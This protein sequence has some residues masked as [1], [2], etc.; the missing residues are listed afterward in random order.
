M[1]SGDDGGELSARRRGRP[2]PAGRSPF[3]P[4][5]SYG[6]LSDC[7]TTTLIA[8]SGNVEWLCLPRPDSPSVFGSML[9]RSAGG[10]RIGPTDVTVPAG[11]RYLPGTLVIE[12]TWQLPTG[13]L[14][15]RDALCV[16]PWYHDTHR[17]HSYRRSPTD[18]EAE[19]VLLRT[20][21]CVSGTA[22]VSLTC[23]PVFDYGRRAGHW[24]Y[25]GDGYGDAVLA[26]EGSD[27]ELH[28]TTNMR[29]GFEGRGAHARTQMK[30]GENVFVALA[31]GEQAPPTTWD[32]AYDRSWRTAEYWR[33]WLNHGDFPDHP[34]R[35]Q[36]QRSALTLKGLTYAPTGALLAAATTS[37]PETPGGERNWD[38]R[39]SWIRDSTFALWGLYT[40]GFDA[41]ANDF[42]YFI[43]D[44]CD[45]DH[46]L[47]IMYG[48]GGERRLDEH[49]LDHLSGYEGARPV[50]IGN[51]AYDQEQH[52][53][54]GAVLDSVYIHTKSRDYLPERVWPLLKLQ[55]EA[56][57]ENWA[58]PDRGIW[59]VR[60]E[61]RHF[62]SSKM[63][64]W[65]AVDRG[66]RLARLHDDD[67]LADA[68][69]KVATEI[70]ADICEHGV[71]Q[72]GV[73]V[74][75]YDTEA[76][77]ASNLLLPLVRFLP[78]DDRR[79]RATVLAIADELTVDGLVLR[80]R[81]EETDDGLSGEEG[82][83]AI[84][85]FWL[86][87]ALSEIGEHDRAHQL[88]ERLLSFASPLQLYA[89]EIDPKS[90]R[91]L[92]NFPQAF[93]HL[94]LINALMHVIKAE[95][96]QD[97]RRFVTPRPLSS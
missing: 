8:P 15:T 68:W 19:H 77:D 10:F 56:A 97:T 33:L 82:T 16:R 76:L 57:I 29:L 92:G 54:W 6:F 53:V 7:E 83:F 90:G 25:Q 63:M 26:V 34:W 46:P 45:G 51:G 30:E 22:E 55:V 58:K 85:S 52:D 89:E 14:I 94:A 21:R 17:S 39:Y 2:T 84:C 96:R 80:Y 35:T 88:C 13:W 71:D 62:T 78:S 38:Y 95:D 44:A 31:W 59:E 18:F 74:Q 28:L 43:A 1:T 4:I 48:V 36:L 41:E 37:L 40:L 5:A 3:P 70:H 75:H 9:D 49:V 23:E 69:E 20:V 72:R 12:T 50:R 87:S 47:Q 67:D 79:V 64:C 24:E 81:V 60:G 61:P 86:A 91:H 32:D 27:L 66:M 11:R 73:F 65:V 93:T 42:F